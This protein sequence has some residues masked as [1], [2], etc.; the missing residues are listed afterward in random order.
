MKRNK[1]QKGFVGAMKFEEKDY[2]L[3]IMQ[4]SPLKLLKISPNIVGSSNPFVHFSFSN[5]MSK[6][7]H[8]Y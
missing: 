1:K 4:R 3:Y 8:A 7:Y 6:Q 2:S 5:V